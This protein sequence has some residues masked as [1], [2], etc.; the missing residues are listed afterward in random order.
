MHTPN[1]TKDLLSLPSKTLLQRKNPLPSGKAQNKTS[2]NKR[3]WRSGRAGARPPGGRVFF[4]QR[5]QGL[6][7]GLERGLRR[8]GTP[9]TGPFP[10]PG[11]QPT[12][13]NEQPASVCTHSTK[14]RICTHL[15][16][17]GLQNMNNSPCQV[18]AGRLAREQ[19]STLC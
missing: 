1:Q 13:H 11:G 6:F 4:A 5:K 16:T 18:S 19:K 9:L 2:Q 17:S 15:T 3:H 10:P 7:G 14:Q 8:G 12:T